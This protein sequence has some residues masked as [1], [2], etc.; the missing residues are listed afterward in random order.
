MVFLIPTY[1]KEISDTVY[2]CIFFSTE[3]ELKIGY[4]RH[5]VMEALRR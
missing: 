3:V 4:R 2:V 1:R 5:V